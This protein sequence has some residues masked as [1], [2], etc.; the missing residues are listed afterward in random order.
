MNPALRE[1]LIEWASCPAAWGLFFGAAA[2][3]LSLP[4]RVQWRSRLGVLFG[5]VSLACIFAYMPQAGSWSE[6]FVFWLLA[7]GSIVAATMMICSRSAVYSALWFAAT[8]IGVSGLFL[9]QGAQFL[10]VATVVVYA[11]AIV[12]TFLFVVMLAQPEGHAMYDRLSWGEMPK[13]LSVLA[14]ASLLGLSL[15]A[16]GP[17]RAEA[18]TLSKTKPKPAVETTEG[19]AVAAVEEIDTGVFSPDHMTMLG[20]NLFSTHLVAVEVAGTLLLVALV[21]AI[22]IS[23]HSRPDASRWPQS[24]D[25]KGGRHHG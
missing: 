19:E 22:A 20:R 6:Q 13:P 25:G 7:G 8:L 12:V 4:P 11:G 21:G 9:V 24:A 16:L 5:A 15:S 18:I 3:L 2:I 17:T 1:K 10:G 23:I 14:A